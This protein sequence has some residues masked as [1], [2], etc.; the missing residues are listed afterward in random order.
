MPTPNHP[1]AMTPLDHQ[2]RKE[3]NETNDCTVIATVH[4]AQ[5][6]YSE[7]HRV[8]ASVG[9][10]PRKGCSF[11]RVAQQLGLRKM[12]LCSG[13][14]RSV[15]PQLDKGRFVIRVP[16]HVIPV[17]DGQ[18]KDW[19]SPQSLRRVRAIYTSNQPPVHL[20]NYLFGQTSTINKN[21]NMAK[22]NINDIED[23]NQLVGCSTAELVEIYNELTGEKVSRFASRDAGL[24]RI[25]KV[26][27]A[28]RGAPAPATAEPT[29]NPEAPEPK[30]R[31][32]NRAPLA[33]QRPFNPNSNR[34]KLITAMLKGATVEQLVEAVPGYAAKIHHHIIN[35]NSWHGYGLRQDPTTGV[36]T[37]YIN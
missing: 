21:D 6:H 8:C 12:R 26:L 30:A 3:L 10:K 35:S 20:P 19:V 4:V 24:K 9:R 16:G 28:R 15:L 13:T 2:A 25:A 23:I 22:P 36:I 32:Y 37:A 7:A 27:R 33:T 14:V 29:P 1:T 5:M 18:I 31:G 17:V 34:G 11:H